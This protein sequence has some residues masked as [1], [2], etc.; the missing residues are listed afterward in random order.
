MIG[1]TDFLRTCPTNDV[2]GGIDNDQFNRVSPDA[3]ANHPFGNRVDGS[4]CC[5]GRRMLTD[6]GGLSRFV[7]A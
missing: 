7:L 5:T 3:C 1:G 4:E 6:Q 2:S